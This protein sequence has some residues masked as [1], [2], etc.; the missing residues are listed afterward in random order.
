MYLE[1]LRLYADKL[2]AAGFRAWVLPADQ[3]NSV[4]ELLCLVD[5]DALK[6][7]YVFQIMYIN[8]LVQAQGARSNETDMTL[9]QLTMRLPFPVAEPQFADVGR[10]LHLL[11]VMMPIGHLILSEVENA[12]S[13]R[14]VLTHS[15]EHIE[16]WLVVEAVKMI[17][18]FVIQF[19]VLIEQAAKGE[20][21]YAQIVQALTKQGQRLS[22]GI[23]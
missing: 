14:G 7:D 12:I 3:V 9:L 13:F 6:R 16:S 11:N 15:S 17:Q 1:Q 20:R 23:S 19:A 10:L 5:V 4:N 8:E 18:F 22:A 2:E 21:S